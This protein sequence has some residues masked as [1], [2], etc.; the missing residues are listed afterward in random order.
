MITGAFEEFQ[1]NEKRKTR[2]CDKRVH[3]GRR[4][5]RAHCV[6]EYK[7]QYYVWSLEQKRKEKQ[8][9]STYMQRKGQGKE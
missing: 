6:L 2:C 1:Q 8:P 3:S 5:M 7:N 9:A 4:Q